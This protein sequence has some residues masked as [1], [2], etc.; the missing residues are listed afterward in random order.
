MGGVN[1]SCGPESGSAPD[2]EGLGSGA[3]L[4]M[5]AQAGARHL[6]R[7]RSCCRLRSASRSATTSLGAGSDRVADCDAHSK[8]ML[9]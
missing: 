2:A 1:T 4:T 7:E 9:L 5:R 3:R 8:Q 6:R